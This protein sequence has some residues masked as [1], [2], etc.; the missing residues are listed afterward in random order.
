MKSCI[1]CGGTSLTDIFHP[2]SDQPLARYA[3][4]LDKKQALASK[5]FAINVVGCE[6]CKHFFNCA[7]DPSAISYLDEN[8]Q[9]GRPFSKAYNDYQEKQATKIKNKYLLKNK[10]ILEVGCG[11]GEFLKQFSDKNTLI[12]YEPSPESKQVSG[13]VVSVINEYFVPEVSIHKDLKPSLIIMRQVLEHVTDPM[14]FLKTFFSMLS[15]NKSE[16]K[17]L[18]L[19]VPSNNKTIEK[20]RFSDFY[21]DHASY[22]SISSLSYALHSAGFF[23]EDISL[24]FDEE[25]ISCLASINEFHQIEATLNLNIE[26]WTSI[27]NNYDLNNKSIMFWGTA[28]TGTMFLNLLN[29]NSEKY[30]YVID[31]DERK[32]KKYIPGTGQLVVAPKFFKSYKPDVVI[33]LS[34]LHSKEIKESILGLVNYDIEILTIK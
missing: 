22:F 2:A 9:E 15:D 27:I 20:N 5:R 6:H 16:I 14:K 10:T 11:N 33:I 3:L 31:S 8:I 17:L 34:Q 13:D 4:N 12:C 28:G 18:Y 23:I 30:P 1:I 29:I 19:E 25:I 7:F 21:Y 26:Y 24:D 32:Q